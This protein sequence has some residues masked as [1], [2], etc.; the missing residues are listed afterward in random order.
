MPS[1]RATFVCQHVFDRSRS[2]D[3]VCYDGDIIVTCSGSDHNFANSKEVH[4][5]GL[6]HLTARDPTL[7]DIPELRMGAWAE[8]SENDRRWRV[9]QE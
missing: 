5:V 1:N 6:G 7:L 8:R 9:S 4:I 3:Y 2:M